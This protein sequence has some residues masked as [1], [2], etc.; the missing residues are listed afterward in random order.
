MEF[1]NYTPFTA[2]P[3]T[4]ED[5]T[6]QAFGVLLVKAVFRLE[7]TS[8]GDR[9]VLK[10]A[11]PQP[12]PFSKD[13][14]HGEPG[15]SS[16]R[17][18]SDYVPLKPRAD[19]VVNAI[20]RSPHGVPARTWPVFV[21]VGPIRKVLQI[22]GPRAWR[23]SVLGG[24]SLGDPAPCER[25]PVQYE[26]AFGGAAV[27]RRSGAKEEWLSFSHRNPIGCGWI[28]PG[29][30][31][32]EVAA[33]Q[34]EDPDHIITSP[35]DRPPPAGL[36]AIHRSW[37]PRLAL[38]G[39]FDEAWLAAR[40][41]HLPGDFDFAHHNSAHRD[42]TAPGYLRGDETVKLGGLL[43]GPF[44]HRFTLPGYTL[45][46]TIKLGDGPDVLV[47]MSLDTLVVDAMADDPGEWRVHLSWRS[48][49]ALTPAV[50][51]L[52]ASMLQPADRER[53]RRRTAGDETP[54]GAV[55]PHGSP[56]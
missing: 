7:A 48:A 5:A 30:D 17:F 33:P 28:D 27:R 1:N 40:W 10:P 44:E 51:K 49:H 22:T 23:R 38:A 52:E 41:P 35:H 25:V 12:P 56:A 15:K 13:E 50:Q 34:I 42:L 8:S 24:W 46:K 26:R 32:R 3:W 16:V 31:E 39:T 29:M 55:A 20:A 36:C 37:H 6:T 2:I 4:T 43:P 19:V 18:E 53:W 47:K 14:F 21:E 45:I 11:C 9:W 54:A